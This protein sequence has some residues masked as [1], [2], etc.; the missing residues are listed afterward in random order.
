MTTLTKEKMALNFIA[1]W[2]LLVYHVISVFGGM[3]FLTVLIVGG[4]RLLTGS[5]R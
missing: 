1:I 4:G 5:T 3:H 2:D